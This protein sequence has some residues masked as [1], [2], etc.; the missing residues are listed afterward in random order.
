MD[1][2]EQAR[3]FFA[4]DTF[5]A[6]TTGI[7]VVHAEKDSAVCRLELEQKHMNANGVAMGG[8]IF[9]LA[10]LA[11]AV[12]ANTDNPKTVTLNSSI[13]FAAPPK[14]KILTAQAR[15]L[16]S[17]RR[18]TIYSVDV[19]DDEGTLVASALITGMR[20]ENEKGVTADG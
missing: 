4:R 5:S 9:T 20:T 15:C 1:L 10:D 11:F 16:K 6:Q 2:T 19:T 7:T 13:N 12:A 14:G 3:E 8:V 17:G 18:T